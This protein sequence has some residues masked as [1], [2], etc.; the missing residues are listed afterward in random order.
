MCPWVHAALIASNKDTQFILSTFKPEL[1]R[2]ADKVY[3]PSAPLVVQ[4]CSVLASENSRLHFARMAVL[5]GGNAQQAIVANAQY[6]GRG[7]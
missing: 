3:S 2:G 4:A 5:P 6:R 7:L 1:A